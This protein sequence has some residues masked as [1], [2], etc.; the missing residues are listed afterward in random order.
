MGKQRNDISQIRKYLDGE[1][2]ARAM[3]E[4]ERRAQDD[5]FLMDALE[6]YENTKADEQKD[7]DELTKRLQQRIEKK[8]AKIIPWRFISIAATILMVLTAGGLL[9]FKKQPVTE[10]KTAQLIMPAP[11]KNVDTTIDLAMP[12]A[13]DKQLASSAPA[14]SAPHLT[15]RKKIVDAPTE[16][17][18]SATDANMISSEPPV[19]EYAAAP[20]QDVVRAAPSSS[21]KEIVASDYFA[22]KRKSDTVAL[23]KALQGRV[24]GVQMNDAEGH[25]YGGFN[26]QLKT[27]RGIIVAKDDGD[28][29]PGAI[30]KVDGAKFGAVTDANGKFTLPNVA[31]NATLAVG[32]IGYESKKVNINKNDSLAIALSPN[33]KSLNEVVV[34]GLGAAKDD[35]GINPTGPYP[36]DGWRAFKKYL[37]DNATSPDGKAGK[38]KLSFMVDGSGNLSDFH[39]SKSL[40]TNADNKA[41]SLIQNGPEWSPANDGKPAK[42]KLIITFN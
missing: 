39:I 7:L 9:F 4:L 11:K 37:I 28:P 29:I 41:I 24:A 27:V 35:N 5:P 38:V 26:P 3:H 30:V 21:L 22:Q 16:K 19:S 14:M 17:I 42:V 2:D 6:G 32:Y 13:E 10:L 33:N 1:L 15:V 18:A 20:S 8:E 40:S 31:D 25:N 23:E 36:K 12:A 34:A